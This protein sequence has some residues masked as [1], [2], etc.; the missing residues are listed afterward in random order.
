MTTLAT[1]IRQLEILVD[2]AELDD[3]ESDF[4]M[5]IVAR[6]AGVEMDL[7]RLTLADIEH[8]QQIHERHFS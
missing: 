2:T 6:T 5:S 7:R 1:K 8:L 4:V 3:R